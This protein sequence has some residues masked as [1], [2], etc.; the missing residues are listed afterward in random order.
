MALTTINDKYLAEIADS[1][2][3]KLNTDTQYK[4][5]EMAAA[6]QEIKGGQEVN[7][8]VARCLY[9]TG[10]ARYLFANTQYDKLIES[11]GNLIT[12]QDLTQTERM[13]YISEVKS[14]PF[15]INFAPDVDYQWSD[16][17]FSY[18]FWGCS[19]LEQLPQMRGNA[20]P[21]NLQHFCNSCHMLTGHISLDCFNW[22]LMNKDL[23]LNKANSMFYHCNSLRSVSE[24]T[25]SKLYTKG[26]ANTYYQFAHTY[27]MFA[28]CYVLDEVIGLHPFIGSVF[29][30]NAFV[31][32]FKNCYRL[33]EVIFAPIS[34][35]TNWKNQSIDLTK[36][37]YAGMTKSILDYNSGITADKEV[38]DAATYNALK[39]DPDWFTLDINYARYNH[40][41]AVNTINSLPDNGSGSGNTIKFKKGMGKLTDGGAVD[42]LTEEE[43]AVAVSK[44]WTVSYA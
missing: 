10:D 27:N 43:I 11:Y 2:R 22:E 41:S 44:G 28:E 13:F 37:G 25:L 40:N 1:I 39:N 35:T 33:K 32:T 24:D 23:E 12:T 17:N 38:K 30:S 20:A 5:K 21:S 26:T 36:I 42:N 34:S 19:K 8:E 6:I 9:F 31:D 7:T 16:K 3:S 29:T 15:S 14:I 18:M 4:P